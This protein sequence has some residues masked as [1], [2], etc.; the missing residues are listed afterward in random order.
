MGQMIAFKRPDGKEC[1]GYLA[2]ATQ[3]NPGSPSVVM[4]QEWWGLNAQMQGL[5]DRMAAAGFNTLVPDLYHG[6]L[7]K[8][9]DEASHLMNTL[10][11][12]QAAH[13]DI[14][15]AVTYLKSLGGKVGVMGY[16]MGGAL[17][18]AAGVHVADVSAAVCLYGMPPKEFADPVN[19]KIP[20]QGHFANIDDWCTP[21]AVNDMEASMNA[22]GL[23][24][25]IYRYDAQHA[26]CNEKRPEV[27]NAACATQAWD[28]T[29]AFWK[30]HLA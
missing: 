28:R 23:K 14:K 11:F 19:I 16:C 1:R 12:P 17:T 27:Y 15:G 22:V 9:A 7:A 10:D 5:A 25:E 26:F 29:V 20:F 2:R 8:D 21:A 3:G 30:K 4:L 13:Q 6:T 18:I 24:P